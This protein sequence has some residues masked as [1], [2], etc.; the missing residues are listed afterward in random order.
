MGA[1]CC[2]EAKLGHEYS[3]RVSRALFRGAGVSRMKASG[4]AV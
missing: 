3:E 2:P 1:S 4:T